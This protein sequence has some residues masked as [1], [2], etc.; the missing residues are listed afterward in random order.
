MP[1]A[2]ARAGAPNCIRP[3]LVERN[4]RISPIQSDS[5]SHGLAPGG[6]ALAVFELG[7]AAGVAGCGASSLAAHLPAHG[8]RVISP[9]HT[10]HHRPGRSAPA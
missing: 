5:S 4:K 8:S 2:L 6:S 10:A 1:L 9:A 7:L 3:W